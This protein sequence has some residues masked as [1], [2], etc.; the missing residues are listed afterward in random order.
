MVRRLEQITGWEKIANTWQ[1]ISRVRNDLAHC[2]MREIR[3]DAKTLENNVLAIPGEL[4]NV[5][6]ELSKL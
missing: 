6:Q 5:Y 1:K 3:K 2:G 4:E